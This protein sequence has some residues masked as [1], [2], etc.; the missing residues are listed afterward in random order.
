MRLAVSRRAAP[1]LSV[2]RLCELARARGLDGVEL[3]AADLPDA[4]AL[5]GAS[6]FFAG[7]FV[8]SAEAVASRD[9]ARA[10]A[11]LGAPV[12]A[13]RELTP[14]L[15]GSLAALDAVYRSEHAELFLAHRT[16]VEDVVP[17]VDSLARAGAQAVGLAWDI[18]TRRDDLTEAPAMLLAT[19][20]ALRFIRL[21]GGGPELADED[22]PAT[23]ELVSSIARARYG[24]VVALTPS[25]DD[26]LG[27]WG[28]WL[29]GKV[30]NG[31]GTAHEK[32][33][34]RAA[35]VML[36]IRTV[37]PKDRMETILGAYR[38]LSPGRTLH[39]TFD[40]DPSCMFYT[41]RATEPEGSFV[42]EK[43]DN[44]PDT[45]KANVTKRAV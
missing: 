9:T 42:F 15:A 4:R 19:M 10:A 20:G 1:D 41:L 37:E 14:A 39:V 13:A 18:D 24:G 26:R 30:K 35:D 31:C 43:K 34:A 32:K 25:S 21:R 36:D 27:A 16:A 38:S 12:V 33:M 40:H 45:W 7:V 3:S 5:S 8:D 29:V 6:G 44:G 22:G 17:L 11:A 23:G 28:D 2:S